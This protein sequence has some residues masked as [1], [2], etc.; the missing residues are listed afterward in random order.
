MARRAAWD[1][2]PIE[3]EIE[4]MAGVRPIDTYTGTP[5]RDGRLDCPCG[6]AIPEGHRLV[7]LVCLRSGID[8]ILRPALA[9]A[10]ARDQHQ[11]GHEPAKFQPRIKDSAA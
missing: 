3:S 5:Q 1:E 4:P 6:G 8:H 7:C 10:R 2:F 9:R 11:N